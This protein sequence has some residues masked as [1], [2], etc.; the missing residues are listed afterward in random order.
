MKTGT[1]ENGL[2][3]QYFIANNIAYY[4]AICNIMFNNYKFNMVIIGYN[5]QFL[6]IF[7]LPAEVLLYAFVQA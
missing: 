5:Y 6:D 7:S 3:L 2:M 4:S 1:P